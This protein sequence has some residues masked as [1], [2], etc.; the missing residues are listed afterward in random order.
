M[1]QGGLLLGGLPAPGHGGDEDGDVLLAHS[2]DK[3]CLVM[4]HERVHMGCQHLDWQIE[5]LSELHANNGRDSLEEGAAEE[6]H[7][8]LAQQAVPGAGL[9]AGR[10]QGSGSIPGGPA[11]G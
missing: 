3:G 11:V 7:C 9:A 1:G 8:L 10:H 5:V 4:D 2:S 6:H